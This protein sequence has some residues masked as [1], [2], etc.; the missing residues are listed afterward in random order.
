MV[1]GQDFDPTKMITDNAERRRTQ[2][3][4]KNRSADYY[5]A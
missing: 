4:W 5:K 2:I 3:M 1:V